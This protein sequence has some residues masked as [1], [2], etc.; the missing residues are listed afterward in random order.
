MDAATRAAVTA[1]AVRP[2]GRGLCRAPAPSSSSPTPAK[3]CGRPHLVHGD[4][5]PPAGR[6]SGHRDGHRPRPGRMAVARRR[7]RAPAAGAGRD[8]VDGWAME[9]RLYAENPATGFLPST[10]KL[11]HF[12][13]VTP[14]P[15]TPTASIAST[16]ASRRAARSSP[17]FYDPMI[18][19]L[20][21]H[22][23]LPDERRPRADAAMSAEARRRCRRWPRPCDIRHGRGLAGPRPTPAK[24]PGAAACEAGQTRPC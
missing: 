10:G 7:R 22:A 2:P 5:H 12:G 15:M 11:E 17:A 14:C 20:I 13:E 1:A 16:P 23:G 8:H 4:E 3:A 24:V 6:A 9:A 18:A 21:A 19:K